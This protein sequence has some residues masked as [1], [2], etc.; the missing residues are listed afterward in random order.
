M[1][2]EMK[3]DS[4]TSWRRMPL[5]RSSRVRW[6]SESMIDGPAID[7]DDQLYLLFTFSLYVCVYIYIFGL[8]MIKLHD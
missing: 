8:C 2:L 7:D 1:A 5:I 3:V 6:N 4:L